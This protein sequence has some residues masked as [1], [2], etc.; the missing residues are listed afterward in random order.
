MGRKSKFSFEVKEKSVLSYENGE[1]SFD[2]IANKIG[3]G[4][5]TVH[6]GRQTV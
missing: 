3:A 5:T 1:A 4:A 2:S 6:W